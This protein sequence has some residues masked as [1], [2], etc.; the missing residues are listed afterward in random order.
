MSTQELRDARNLP[1][2]DVLG[3]VIRD[4]DGKPRCVCCLAVVP[5]ERVRQ[6]GPLTLKVRPGPLVHGYECVSCGMGE[7]PKDEEEE[8][9]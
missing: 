3:R 5:E 8:E 6:C 9:P 2:F 1:L 7:P 4:D